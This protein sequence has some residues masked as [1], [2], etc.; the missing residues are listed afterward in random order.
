[1]GWAWPSSVPACLLPY[2]CNPDTSYLYLFPGTCFLIILAWFLLPYIY[3]KISITWYSLPDAC[4]LC[5]LPK[6][7]TQYFLL[8]TCNQIR[9]IWFFLHAYYRQHIGKLSSSWQCSSIA[10]W[11]LSYQSSKIYYTAHK[12][13]QICFIDYRLIQSSVV[14]TKL[15]TIWTETWLFITFSSFSLGT[16][17]K[18]PDFYACRYWITRTFC[19]RMLYLL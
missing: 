8:D 16:C 14:L 13:I 17:P 2:S 10:N 6:L 19:L 4:Y 12:T 1:M 7:F 3:Y 15:G 18:S 5:L 11:D 9:N